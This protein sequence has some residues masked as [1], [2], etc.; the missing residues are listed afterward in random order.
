[1]MI[2]LTPTSIHYPICLLVTNFHSHLMKR[3]RSRNHIVAS[4]LRL[5]TEKGGLGITNIMYGSYLSYQQVAQYLQLIKENGLLDYDEKSGLYRITEKGL[6]YLE[7]YDK[8]DELLKE[9]RPS[10]TDSLILL[11][12]YVF[13]PILPVLGELI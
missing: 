7:L 8:M 1:M 4:I 10:V 13:Y 11:L 2:R 3:Q 6:Q 9:G 12:C 5:V